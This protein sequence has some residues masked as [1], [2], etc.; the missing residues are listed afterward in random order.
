MIEDSMVGTF[1]SAARNLLAQNWWDED[2][3]PIA[4]TFNR[5]VVSGSVSA[6]IRS[7]L[8]S[9]AL[10]DPPRSKSSKR[11]FEGRSSTG[12]DIVVPTCH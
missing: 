10:R 12:W 8:P 4:V 7:P 11:L 9:I 5:A 2:D 1:Q 3:L 6:M